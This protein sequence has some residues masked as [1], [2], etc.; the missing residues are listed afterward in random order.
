M[1]K[2]VRFNRESSLTTIFFCDNKKRVPYEKEKSEM[3]KEDRLGLRNVATHEQLASYTIGILKRASQNGVRPIA[4][5]CGPITTGGK[6]PFY[7]YDRLRKTI[8]LLKKSGKQGIEVFDHLPYYWKGIELQRKEAEVVGAPLIGP[9]QVP[10]GIRI[11]H[12]IPHANEAAMRRREQLRREFLGPLFMSGLIKTVYLLSGWE[13]SIDSLW[14]AEKAAELGISVELL[15]KN[16][17]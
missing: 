5:V 11:R 15:P 12:N 4:I 10:T 1:E 14:C 6:D 17:A 16:F 8:M 7:N 2:K 3:M 13:G 9:L